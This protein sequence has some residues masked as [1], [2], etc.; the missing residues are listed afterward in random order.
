[1]ESKKVGKREAVFLGGESAWTGLS[2]LKCN[3]AT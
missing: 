3:S 1:M 2:E